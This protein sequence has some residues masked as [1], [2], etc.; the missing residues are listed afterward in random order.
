M[1]VYYS[2]NSGI[3]HK[4]CLLIDPNWGIVDSSNSATFCPLNLQKIVID[5]IESHLSCHMLLPKSDGSFVKNANEIWIE[6][7]GEIFQFCKN[8]NLLRLWIYLWKEWYSKEKWIL[9]A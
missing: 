9:W 4:E 5:L 2:Y 7:I 8:N 3:A 1:S 6:C